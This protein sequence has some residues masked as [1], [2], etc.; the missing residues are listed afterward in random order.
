MADTRFNLIT[1]GADDFLGGQDASKIP[2]RIAAN[3]YAAGINVSV[4]RAS[5]TPRWGFAREVINFPEGGVTDFAGRLH[6]YRELFEAGKFQLAAPYTVSGVNCIVIVMAGIIFLFNSESENLSVIDI[7]G[8][9]HLNGRAPRL[10]WSPAGKYLVIYDF[11][12]YPVLVDGIQARRANPADMEVPV[13][14][15]G[16]YNENRLFVAN[17]GNE[18]TGG[19]VVGNIATP[20]A[21][22]TFEEVFTTGS[23]YLAQ[24]FSLPTS[25]H[26]DSITYMGFL[27]MADSST[28]IGPMIVG[29]SRSVF[30]FRTDTP[31][32]DWDQEQFGSLLCYD[33]GI[34]GPRA[35][36]N[37]NSDAFFLAQDGYVRSLSMSR[38]EQ[39]KWSRV[40][41]SREVENWF[42]YRDK[43]LISLG[44]VSYFKNKVFF[45]VNPYRTKVID[46][47][48]YAPISDYAH[49]GMVV[50]ELDSLTSFGD[51]VKPVWGGLWTGINPMDMV[52]CGERAFIISKDS[53]NIN[54]IYEVNPNLTYDTADG[55]MRPVRSRVYTKEYD[56]KNPFENKELHSIDFN[57]DTIEG[58][59]SIEVKYK[60]SHSPYMIPWRTFTHKAPWR[61]C[62]IP[63]GCFL[64]GFAPHHIRDFTLGAPGGIECSPVTNDFYKIFRKVQLELT[65]TGTYWEIHEYVIKAM[66]RPKT[67]TNTIPCVEYPKVSICD[68]CNDD[69]ATAEFEGC[70]QLTT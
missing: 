20:D 59:F 36:A 18:F 5:I 9:T 49:G 8:G 40:P 47:P 34:V 16:T 15:L 25:A 38:D 22:I 48:T 28:G 19:D 35:F 44:F 6:T 23:P 29:T 56:F 46:F 2:D 60:A 33:A 30:S 37:V 58:D 69:W 31:R 63:E 61:T 52:N 68:V 54:R 32:S 10:S 39:H 51:A 57:F 27:Q 45:S 42:K 26:N 62:S 14:T 67:E 3:C 55:K 50:M 21:P 65:L 4:K 64:N 7:K 66:P 53:S 70:Q 41:L 13:S 24:V 17:D 43:S 1:D 12:A 11:P